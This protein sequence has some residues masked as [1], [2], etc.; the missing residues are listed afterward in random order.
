MNIRVPK[1]ARNWFTSWETVSFSRRTPLHAGSTLR[2][3]YGLHSSMTKLDVWRYK[4]HSRQPDYH[5]MPLDTTYTK[6]DFHPPSARRIRLPNTSTFRH[7]IHI[8]NASPSPP[9]LPRGQLTHYTTCL[10]AVLTAAVGHKQSKYLGAT[11]NF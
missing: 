11:S 2:D 7:N 4:P 9:Y 8:H 6:G 10:S 5:R 3:N 1:N